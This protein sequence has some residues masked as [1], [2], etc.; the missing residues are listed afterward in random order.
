MGMLENPVEHVAELHQGQ[1]LSG[2]S[3]LA[4]T[5]ISSWAA[6]GQLPTLKGP[7]STP[8][9]SSGCPQLWLQSPLTPNPGDNS[10]RL[11][12]HSFPPQAC[13]QLSTLIVLDIQ[14][15]RT[16]MGGSYFHKDQF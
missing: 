8:G 5:P 13:S 9:D 3:Y 16:C 6:K 7:S 10:K 1:I 4:I 14:L 15:L 2:Q 12:T 11:Q